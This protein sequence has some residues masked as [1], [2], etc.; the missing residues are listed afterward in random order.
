MLTMIFEHIS[1]LIVTCISF[2]M[3]FF[4]D[5]NGYKKIVDNEKYNLVINVHPNIPIYF[6]HLLPL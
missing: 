2:M 5:F 1:N 6:K 3:F 4:V